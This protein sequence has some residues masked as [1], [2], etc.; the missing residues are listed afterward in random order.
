MVVAGGFFVLLLLYLYE[1]D[2]DNMV[3]FGVIAPASIYYRPF[4]DPGLTDPRVN[5]KSREK[6]SHGNLIT[7]DPIIQDSP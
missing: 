5:K 7:R 2:S 3:R 1:I 4:P 6:M